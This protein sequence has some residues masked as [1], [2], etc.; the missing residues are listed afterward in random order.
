MKTMYSVLVALLLMPS[1][2][3]AGSF[4]TEIV[5]S[6]ENP[7]PLAPFHVWVTVALPF[8]CWTLGTQGVSDFMVNDSCSTGDVHT[9][10][11]FMATMDFDTLG[12]LAEGYH[13]LTITEWHDGVRDPGQWDHV[14][15]ITVG[16]PPVAADAR[17][18]SAV[19]ALYR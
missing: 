4:V 5:V 10:P 3:F 16:T 12:G 6:P 1:L 19:K 18:W 9:T 7:A 14:L 2:V 17:T 13:T 15:E 8:P 11:L